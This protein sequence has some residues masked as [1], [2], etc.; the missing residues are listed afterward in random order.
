[1]TTAQ[2]DRLARQHERDLLTVLEAYRGGNL[3]ARLPDDWR[4]LDGLV[5]EALNQV[6]DRANDTR[7]ELERLAMLD[8]DEGAA[9]NSEPE[10]VPGGAAATPGMQQ[11]AMRPPSWW[12]ECRVKHLCQGY[13]RRASEDLR[14][15]AKAGEDDRKQSD[16]G[17]TL[18]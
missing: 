3:S 4:G 14:Q 17:P 8:G 16:S 18:G 2:H 1:M 5:A 12:L 9:A 6:L 10:V 7:S 11:P 13:D 15:S